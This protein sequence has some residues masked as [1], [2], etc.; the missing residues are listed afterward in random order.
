M[1]RK[2]A[3][4]MKG[5]P[6]EE[7]KISRTGSADSMLRPAIA[8]VGELRSRLNNCQISDPTELLKLE[9]EIFAV[10]K[11][12]NDPKEVL[13]QSQEGLSAG[14]YLDSVLRSNTE[15]ESPIVYYERGRRAEGD[16]KYKKALEF[17]CEAMR[18]GADNLG[19]INA[20]ARTAFWLG[21]IQAAIKFFYSASASA[22]KD[23]PAELRASF[24]NNYASALR[25]A[26]DHEK[27]ERMLSYA[28]QRASDGSVSLPDQVSM[29]LN[30][31]G[32]IQSSRAKYTEAE[33]SFRKARDI[34][35][36][37]QPV[38]DL[39][40]A[41][42]ENNIAEMMRRVGE[43]RK[44]KEFHK[45][46]LSTR[47]SVL[48]TVSLAVSE[49]YNNLGALAQDEGCFK[50]AEQCLQSALKITEELLGG[51]HSQYAR[52]LNNFGMFQYRIKNF[53]QAKVYLERASGVAEVSAIKG[54]EDAMAIE[55]NY[56][57]AELAAVSNR[58]SSTVIHNTNN[59]SHSVVEGSIYQDIAVKPKGRAMASG[60]GKSKSS[61]IVSNAKIGK[62]V[63]M[64]SDVAA[65]QKFEKSSAE[66]LQMIV[67]TKRGRERL[68]RELGKLAEMREKDPGVPP[69]EA[70][71]L[72]EASDLARQGSVQSAFA[73]LGEVTQKLV[74][75]AEK[76]G[77]SVAAK[78]IEHSLGL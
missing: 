57:K 55:R 36:A 69:S 3:I 59:I 71:I 8:T 28:L 40:I 18:L 21:E 5:E 2:Y 75:V 6:I 50:V 19:V 56:L 63:R 30:N 27:A 65:D 17:Y 74:G 20:A 45:K 77:V 4:D 23:A 49:S 1:F 37:T 46:A 42:I 9:T 51:R 12:C 22:L 62:A 53:E 13:R 76:I 24:L 11:V 60:R 29:I 10:A 58:Q 25:L 73:K 15:I 34:R 43:R 16:F 64:L 7:M 54:S 61:Q 70:R 14:E 38:D 68:A 26:G 44:A 32:V 35:L 67:K 31:L 48:G 66:S 72:R 52:A 33:H 41:Q 39:G 78:A 47:L